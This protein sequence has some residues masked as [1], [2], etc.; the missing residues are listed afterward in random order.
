MKRKFRKILS[1]KAPQLEFFDE[2]FDADQPTAPKKRYLIISSEIF[3]TKK[4]IDRI[5]DLENKY[6]VPINY[7][8]KKNSEEICTRLNLDKINHFKNS[9]FLEYLKKIEAYRTFEDK[10]FGMHVGPNFLINL[11]ALN[12]KNFKEFLELFHSIIFIKSRNRVNQSIL[13]LKINTF[14]TYDKI[15][16]E[17]A[18]EISSNINNMIAQESFIETLSQE[19]KKIIFTISHEDIEVEE[20]R[21]LNRI[22]SFVNDKEKI[23]YKLNKIVVK[24][25]Q[26][27][28]MK[29]VREIENDYLSYILGENF[30]PIISKELI[31]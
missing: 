27:F 16:L 21:S 25:A 8:T 2:N 26:P 15:N 24:T 13:K 19:F 28:N 9:Y 30:S 14:K 17:I 20:D 7:F 18:K 29:L 12:E 22:L 6:G 11:K 10:I 3:F 4:I 1:L 23:E 5:V 31:N